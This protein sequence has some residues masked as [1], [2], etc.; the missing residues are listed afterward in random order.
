MAAN[1]Y[2]EFDTKGFAAILE[3][4]SVYS[5]CESK[6]NEVAAR[7]NANLTEESDGFD[8]KMVQAHGY[9]KVRDSRWIG[10]VYATDHAAKVA[11]SE[12]KAL[13]GA[14]K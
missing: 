5:L 1:I 12:H 14:L 4:G 2:I 9:G 3:S 10:Q 13:S 11:E 7:A 8:V 6:A